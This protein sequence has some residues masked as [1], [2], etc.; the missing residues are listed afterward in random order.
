MPD[1]PD[2]KPDLTQF[3]LP[4]EL[5]T[6]SEL[7][8]GSASSPGIQLVYDLPHPDPSLP[9]GVRAAVTASPETLLPVAVTLSHPGGHIRW[10]AQPGEEIPLW[11]IRAWMPLFS[12]VFMDAGNGDVTSA[13]ATE[14]LR[15]IRVNEQLTDGTHLL[16]APRALLQQLAESG[17]RFPEN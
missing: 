17:E 10:R 7:G 3:Q 13:Y 5:P 11:V 15:R 6:S 1:Q 4:H 8:Y 9:N 2:E 12:A 16:D 14:L